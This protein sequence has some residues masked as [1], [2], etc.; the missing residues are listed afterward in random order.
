MFRKLWMAG[1][2]SVL[3]IGSALAADVEGDLPYDPRP[4]ECRQLTPWHYLCCASCDTADLA[5]LIGHRTEGECNRVRETLIALGHSVS[6]CI[7]Y[8]RSC[9]PDGTLPCHKHY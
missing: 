3:A 8:S 5:G 1:A 9:E 7:E 6:R 2:L 4:H